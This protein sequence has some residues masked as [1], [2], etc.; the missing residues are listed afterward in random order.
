MLIQLTGL[1]KMGK[2]TLAAA[3]HAKIPGSILTKEPGSPHVP[4]NQDIRKIVLN[5]IS[6]SPLE[7][8][9]LFYADASKHKRFIETFKHEDTVIS[10]RGL[11]C[12]LAYLKGYLKTAQIDYETYNLLKRLALSRVCARPDLIFYVRGSLELMKE[13]QKIDNA[14]K[15]A[16]EKNSD[17]FYAAV[18]N[19]Y[20]D[21]YQDPI[22]VSET[23]V[24]DAL[25]P[26]DSNVKTMINLI[27]S[28]RVKK[29][30]ER[31][32]R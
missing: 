29:D 23:Y 13:R 2:S 6:L 28:W 24:L 26:I 1:D 25:N 15:D 11:W 12:H 18:H 5:D 14:Q 8:E 16:I 31:R 9:L 22:S 17:V 30:D 7:R 20:E 32:N 19:T 27:H 21:L 10:D 4:G 3:L